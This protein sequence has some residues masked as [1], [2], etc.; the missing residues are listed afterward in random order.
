MLKMQHFLKHSSVPQMSA[1]V[2]KGFI[3]FQV[4]FAGKSEAEPIGITAQVV[5]KAM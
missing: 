3:Y 4:N 1:L 2:L 5:F